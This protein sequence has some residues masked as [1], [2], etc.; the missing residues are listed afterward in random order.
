MKDLFM[1]AGGAVSLWAIAASVDTGRDQYFL[2][3]VALCCFV[4]AF[5][6]PST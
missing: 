1:L 5:L 2:G 3:F 6:V 4:A